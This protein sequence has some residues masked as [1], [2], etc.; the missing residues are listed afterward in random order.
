M[1]QY[2][3]ITARDY[4]QRYLDADRSALPKPPMLS[5]ANSS[6]EEMASIWKTEW[7]IACFHIKVLTRALDLTLESAVEAKT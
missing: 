2:D 7:E 6:A 1:S 4:A 3:A 5:E